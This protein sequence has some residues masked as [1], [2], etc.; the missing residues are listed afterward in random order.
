[1]RSLGLN[2]GLCAAVLCTAVAD[3]SSDAANP[4][5]STLNLRLMQIATSA[6]GE[7]GVSLVH[8]ES[9]A[10]L[11]SYDADKPFPMASVYKLPIAFEMLS[12]VAEGRLRFDKLVNIGP[13]DIRDCCTLSRRHPNGGITLTLLELMQLMLTESDNTASDAVLDA[14]GGP[15]AVKQRLRAFGF[16]S[17][18]VDR[19]QGEISFAMMG[20]T[21]PPPQSAWTLEIQ[22]QL[23]SK[24][25]FADLNAARIRYTTQ[26]LR[27]TATPADMARFLV[28]L[29]RGELLP[30]SLTDTL[31]GFM[32][33][34]KTGPQRLKALLPPD[35]RVAHKTGTTTVVVND[36]GLITLPHHDGHL[37][38]AVFVKNGPSPA[39]MEHP[40][41]RIAAAAFE[42]FTGESLK[43]TAKPRRRSLR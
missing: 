20:V 29:Q 16:E 42:S 21:D 33:Y 12:Q 35:T 8:V 27:D 10:Q 36:V 41:G 30:Q 23:I 15:Q 14:V 22:K 34:S 3:V 7:I 5:L 38:A 39:A 25:P 26:D 11:F 24:V 18:N 32:S 28:R 2:L 4:G 43:A 31:L 6:P 40:I 1:M 9:G 13:T 19:Y 17:I 37:A